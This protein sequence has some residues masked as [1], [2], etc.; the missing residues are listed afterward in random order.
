MATQNSDSEEPGT[1]WEGYSDYQAISRRVAASVGDALDAY[2][3]LQSVHRE[4]AA[5]DPERAA[6]QRQKILS[7]A[8]RLFVEM[9]EEEDQ[10]NDDY[11]DILERWRGPGEEPGYIQKFHEHNFQSG[12]P[13]WMFQFIVDIRSAGWKLGY[14]QAGRRSKGE[15][16]D[17]AE[18]A[19]RSM[20]D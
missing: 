12:L 18:Q 7:A 16:E 4:G 5:L 6:T 2:A 19:A 9:Q 3:H 10:G 14:L 20:F 8:M 13:G 15:L 1:Y 17:K 11:E